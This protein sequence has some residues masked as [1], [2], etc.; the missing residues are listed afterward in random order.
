MELKIPTDSVYELMNAENPELLQARRPGNK[1]RNAKLG[2]DRVFSLDGHDK[3]M[4]YQNSSSHW[5]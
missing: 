5:P 3:L 2:S 4:G 1:N